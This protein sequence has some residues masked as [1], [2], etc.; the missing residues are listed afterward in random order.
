MGLNDL[1]DH[2]TIPVFESTIGGG[3]GSLSPGYCASNSSLNSLAISAL[4]LIICPLVFP[5]GSLAS[6]DIRDVQRGEVFQ[7]VIV[8]SLSICCAGIEKSVAVE[9]K[10][11]IKE[12][13]VTCV[14]V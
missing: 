9:F 12:P 5:S 7:A 4:I 13:P 1:L 6:L 2:V 11:R 14:F 8:P 3:H 10:T